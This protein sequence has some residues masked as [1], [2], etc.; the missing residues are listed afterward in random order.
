MR[1]QQQKQL[2]QLKQQEYSKSG[3]ANLLGRQTY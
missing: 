3:W 2:L 1:Q